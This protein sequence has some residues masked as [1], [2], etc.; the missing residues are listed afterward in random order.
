MKKKSPLATISRHP[1]FFLQQHPHHH[2]DSPPCPGR[3]WQTSLFWLSQA[4]SWY[5]E[6]R[7][8]SQDHLDSQYHETQTRPWK[9]N[10]SSLL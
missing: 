5:G 4:H 2:S 1:L 6:F 7:L 9:R 3:P 10:V 8:F